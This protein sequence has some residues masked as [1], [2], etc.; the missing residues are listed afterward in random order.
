MLK[1]MN[2]SVL[3]KTIIQ[4]PPEFLILK[5]TLEHEVENGDGEKQRL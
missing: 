2:N 5:R 4:I 1:W 3:D